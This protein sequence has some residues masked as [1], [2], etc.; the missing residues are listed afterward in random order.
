V[1]GREWRVS[2]DIAQISR[3]LVGKHDMIPG[4]ADVINKKDVKLQ[5]ILAKCSAVL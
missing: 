2:D 1:T 3:L 5:A 4:L